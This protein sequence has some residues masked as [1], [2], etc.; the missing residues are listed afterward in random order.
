MQFPRVFNFLRCF[1]SELLLLELPIFFILLFLPFVLKLLALEDLIHIGRLWLP[2]GLS[3]LGTLCN[4]FHFVLFLILDNIRLNLCL[5]LL[6]CLLL[7]LYSSGNLILLFCCL[8]LL[9]LDDLGLDLLLLCFLALLLVIHL[10][11]FNLLDPVLLCLREE[12]FG[13]LNTKK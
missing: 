12:C 13:L 5:M 6:G 3:A 11:P 10:R 2:L 1:F 4:L 9:L 7:R 8:W